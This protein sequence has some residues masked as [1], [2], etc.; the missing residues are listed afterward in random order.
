MPQQKTRVSREERLAVVEEER[1][2][3]LTPDPDGIPERLRIRPSWVLWRL[4]W[5][6]THSKTTKRP[7]PG[8]CFRGY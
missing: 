1:T 8:W 2:R 6:E 5:P 7:T 3:I 4:E